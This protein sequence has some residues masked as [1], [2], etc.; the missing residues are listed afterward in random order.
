MTIKIKLWLLVSL[1]VLSACSHQPVKPTLIQ[2]QDEARV[3]KIISETRLPQAVKGILTEAQ[4][5]SRE[6]DPESALNLTDTQIEQLEATGFSFLDGWITD[7]FNQNQIAEL[8]RG[9]PLVYTPEQ[10][11]KKAAEQKKYEEDAAAKFIKVGQVAP[12]FELSD[13][14]GKTHRLSDYRGKWVFIDFW[15]TWCGPCVA[16]L[17]MINQAYQSVDKSKVE[18]IGICAECSEFDEFIQENPMQWLHLL[19]PDRKVPKLFGLS[20]FPTKALISP[21]GIVVET[22]YT[23]NKRLK[24]DLLRTINYHKK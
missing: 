17:P 21:E 6:N 14:N 24:H 19:D 15:A 1:L 18:F 16:E 12:D 2:Y 23:N 9:N 13:N 22:S 8:R 3:D 7:K 20:S 11:A 4:I 5:L 10:I